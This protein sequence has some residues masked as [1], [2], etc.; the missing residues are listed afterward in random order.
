M[1]ISRDK[2]SAFV[3]KH[4]ALLQDSDG[5]VITE[6]RGLTVGQLEELRGKIREAEGSFAVVKNTL[7]RVALNE[8]G[9]P[10]PEDLLKGPV[11][12][13]FGNK[14]IP[15]VAKAVLDFAKDNE[16]LVVK[17]GM[18]GESII[19]VDSVKAL[20]DLPSIDVLR[21]QLLGLLN[22]PAS[23]LVGVFNAPATEFVG[24]LSGGVRQVLN[25]LNAYSQKGPDE[26]TES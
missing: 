16:L 12:I 20:T 8:V 6:Y 13:A 24:V 17:G 3:E 2:K 23:Q 26:A 15:G 11:G 22:T 25:V 5:F 18:I 4:V 9:L 14:N 1:A 19:D 7:A 10:I 21:A